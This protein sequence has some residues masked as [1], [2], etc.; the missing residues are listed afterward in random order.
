MLYCTGNN[1]TRSNSAYIL[2]KMYNDFTKR[3]SKWLFAVYQKYKIAKK[4]F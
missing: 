1:Q 2:L 3:H 4:N